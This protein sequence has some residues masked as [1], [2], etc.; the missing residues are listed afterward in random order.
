MAAGF[1]AAEWGCK[2][3]F[4]DFELHLCVGKFHISKTP[5]RA[6]EPSFLSTQGFRPSKKNFTAMRGFM[7][8]KGRETLAVTLRLLPCESNRMG[9]KDRC[10]RD[11][12]VHCLLQL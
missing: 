6:K 10:G 9:V 4:S 8:R 2:A 7:T 11:V 1:L 3:A 5:G 12:A